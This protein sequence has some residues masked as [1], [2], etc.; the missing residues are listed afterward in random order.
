MMKQACGRGP[1]RAGKLSGLAAALLLLTAACS[2]PETAQRTGPDDNS[3][4]PLQVF[5]AASLTGPFTTLGE[6]FEDKHG[7]PV[8]FNFAGS[9][10]LVSQIEQGAPAGVFASADEPTMERLQQSGATAAEP[11]VF[12]ANTLVI[13]TPPE[14]PAAIHTLEELAADRVVTVICAPQVP[15]GSATADVAEAAGVELAP[16]S[17]ENAVTDVLGKVRSGEADAGVVYRTDG[18]RAGTDVETIQIEGA[19]QV[20]N[21]YPI[22]VLE[23][24][25]RPEVAQEF[26]DF[27][28][29]PEAQQ[30][31]RDAG[32]AAP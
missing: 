28:L 9:S 11:E 16:A 7:V 21:K 13:V 32:F 12:A 20:V 2:G 15:C 8:D 17:E 19:E 10:N 29:S 1:E 18:L 5:A 22:A 30:I 4:E 26:V 3:E 27:V 6:S 31:L 14:N 25:A 23:G 24:A